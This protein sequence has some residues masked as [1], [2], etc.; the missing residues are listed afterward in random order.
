MAEKM[1][2]L[3]ASPDAAIDPLIG[4]GP[5]SYYI[6]NSHEGIGKYK[7]DVPEHVAHVLLRSS[8]GCVL[9]NPPEPPPLDMT[10]RPFIAPSPGSSMTWNGVHYGPADESGLIML[11]N[12]ATADAISHRFMP[13]VIK[14]D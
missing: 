7:V 9:A 8:A 14:E 3:R 12:A 1:V 5:N 13:A 10:L 6:S 11:P 2:R 4:H